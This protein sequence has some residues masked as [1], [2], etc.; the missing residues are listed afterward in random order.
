MPEQG[1]PTEIRAGAALSGVIASR[2][3]AVGYAVPLTIHEMEI[4]QTGGGVSHETAELERAIGQVASRLE[5]A[6]ASASGTAREIIEAHLAMLEDPELTERAGTLIAE[7][8]SAAYAWR[9]AIRGNIE[10]L[11]ALG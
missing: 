3:L 4:A 11:R 2:G 8:A 7:G 10:A 5:A 6:R 9:Q 1:A